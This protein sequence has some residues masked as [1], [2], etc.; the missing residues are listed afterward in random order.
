MTDIYITLGTLS[1]AVVVVTAYIKKLLNTSGTLTIIISFFV[2]FSISAA[3]WLLNAGIFASLEWFYIIVYGA[4]AA[5]MAN[6]LST[7]EFIKE[8][9]ILLKLK[10]PKE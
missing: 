8:L 1:A 7:W 10:V 2:A 6:G 4:C 3:S 5:L 9:L